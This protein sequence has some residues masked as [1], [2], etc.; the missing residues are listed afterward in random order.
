MEGR[1]KEERKNNAKF[2]GHY[3]CPR[4]CARTLFAPICFIINFHSVELRVD[5]LQS[6]RLNQMPV[7]SQLL[8]GCPTPG[9][10]LY[11]INLDPRLAFHHLLPLH[12]IHRHLVPQI[13]IP[14][15]P[16]SHKKTKSNW[17]IDLTCFCLF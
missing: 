16:R 14:S 9:S 2:S 4:T 17:D 15:H 12:A 6:S 1:K 3:V 13:F 10:H 5:Q 11:T 7:K 8:N